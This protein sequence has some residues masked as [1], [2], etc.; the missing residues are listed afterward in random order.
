MKT[1]NYHPDIA[2]YI[3]CAAVALGERGT[4]GSLMDM[5]KFGPP[6][7]G[8]VPSTDPCSD[9]QIGWCAGEGEIARA[10][11]CHAIWSNLSPGF[12]EILLG[13]YESRQWGPGV[14]GALGDLAGV[15]VVL[16]GSKN[17]SE[18]I[19][20]ATRALAEE[21]AKAGV[22]SAAMPELESAAQS[23]MIPSDWAPVLDACQSLKREQIARRNGWLREAE[24]ALREAH[25]QWE[26]IRGLLTERWAS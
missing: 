16:V 6:Q 2:W 18:R 11:R 21:R 1:P 20:G 5:L 26:D 14:Q 3:Q 4:A 12:Q 23:H 24:K 25:Q 15:V 10:R 13:R 17:A 22:W 19:H 8:G 7:H 9:R